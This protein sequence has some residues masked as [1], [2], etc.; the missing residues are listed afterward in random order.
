MKCRNQLRKNGFKSEEHAFLEKHADFFYIL[1][2]T[3]IFIVVCFLTWAKLGNPFIDCGREAYLPH[4]ILHGN[5][6][7]KDVFNLYN[8]LSI[9][10]NAILYH[11]FGEKLTVLYLAGIANSYLI[12]L[13]AYL[14]TKSLFKPL[15]A[16]SITMVIMAM[17]VFQLD[18][19]NYIFPYTYAMTYA[20]TG[21]LTSVLCGIYAIKN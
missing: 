7:I 8:P 16:F 4:A 18:I 17:G 3:A 20:L 10:I 13:V 11:L 1:T 15:Q 2:L 9:Q 5:V 21:M 19:F 6:L 14:I 12:L